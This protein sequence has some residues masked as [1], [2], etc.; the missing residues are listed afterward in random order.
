M[1]PLLGLVAR[2]TIPLAPL[3]K[4]GKVLLA[5]LKKAETRAYFIVC[6]MGKYS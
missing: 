6:F 5:S 3:K 1:M 2:V 4:G